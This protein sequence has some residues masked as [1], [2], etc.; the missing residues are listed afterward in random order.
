MERRSTSLRD[1]PAGNS[2]FLGRIANRP[3]FDTSYSKQPVICRK[4]LQTTMRAQRG[5]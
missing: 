1:R 4:Q 3:T 2:A 5:S